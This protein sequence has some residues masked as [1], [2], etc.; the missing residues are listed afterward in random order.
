MIDVKKRKSTG[1]IVIGGAATSAKK[2][3]MT[4]K[5]KD[6]CS[7]QHTMNKVW[8]DDFMPKTYWKSAFSPHAISVVYDKDG[9][10]SVDDPCLGNFK[11]LDI[12]NAHF[13]LAYTR[14]LYLFKIVHKS[15]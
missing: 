9:N 5:I 10:G 14:H 6:L 11:P 4:K 12:I 1:Y 3:I 8:T 13:S 2:N 7:D 15:L